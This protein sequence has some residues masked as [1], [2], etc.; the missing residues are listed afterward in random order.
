MEEVS[1]DGRRSWWSTFN[2]SNWSEAGQ[3]VVKTVLYL[4]QLNF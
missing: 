2:D 1:D 3:L 4:C